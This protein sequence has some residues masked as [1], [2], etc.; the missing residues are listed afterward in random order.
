MQHHA[1]DHNI[2]SLQYNRSIPIN[3]STALKF[4]SIT[5]KTSFKPLILH[6][7]NET[8]QEKVTAKSYC[9]DPVRHCLILVD[10]Y[11]PSYLKIIG[12]KFDIIVRRTSFYIEAFNPTADPVSF[13]IL[14][15]SLNDLEY[16]FSG[17]TCRS[18]HWPK[19][20]SPFGEAK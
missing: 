17:H 7:Q 2:T 10:T 6:Q 5:L 13:F 18:P 12:T 8:W 20:A 1:K 16:N 11:F 14:I 3:W 19:R 4:R 15:Q 9:P